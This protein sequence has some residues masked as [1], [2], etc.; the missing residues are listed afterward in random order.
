MYIWFADPQAALRRI[1][2]KRFLTSPSS[3]DLAP[4]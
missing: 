4:R 2:D 3:W 1:S